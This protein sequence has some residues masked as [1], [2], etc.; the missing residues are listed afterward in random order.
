LDLI[1]LL[2]KSIQQTHWCLLFH[3][4][5]SWSLRIHLWSLLCFRQSLQVQFFH[6][7]IIS[8]VSWW[9]RSIWPKWRHYSRVSWIPL[10]S[11]LC[12]LHYSNSKWLLWLYWPQ[13][14]HL[15]WLLRL[16]LTLAFYSSMELPCRVHLALHKDCYNS[17]LQVFSLQNWFFICP[18]TGL[19]FFH[20]TTM[21]STPCS[22]PGLLQLFFFDS[23]W[24]YHVEYTLL[25][26][27]LVTT[28]FFKLFQYIKL[29]RHLSIHGTSL[30]PNFLRTSLCLYRVI[31][32]SRRSTHPSVFSW[33]IHISMRRIIG[34]N[35]LVSQKT[36]GSLRECCASDSWLAIVKIKTSQR[37]LKKNIQVS[38]WPHYL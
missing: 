19:L 12:W 21:S 22:S 20:G 38:S 37:F 14:V 10:S 29:F 32:G 23:P 2:W 5:A 36:G 13:G 25:F 11:Y 1:R 9:F 33:T 17:F 4:A 35:P 16:L 18:T 31:P 3:L 7:D 6:F 26:T 24:N 28:P 34:P 8:D 27:R 15:A 30:L